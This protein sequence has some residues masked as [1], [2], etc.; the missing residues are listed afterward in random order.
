MSESTR[1]ACFHYMT[2]SHTNQGVF[3]H[4]FTCLG[5]SSHSLHY[6]Q[7]KVD[8]EQSDIHMQGQCLAGFNQHGWAT[9]RH[10]AV[11]LL[12]IQSEVESV[13]SYRLG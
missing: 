4:Y 10:P 8:A 5:S 6:I 1:G 9:L 3:A 12:Q 7:G 11:E 13:I 2:L